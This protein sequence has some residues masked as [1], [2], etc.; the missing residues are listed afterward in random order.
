[1]VVVEVVLQGRL[2]GLTRL[3]ILE[4]HLL[5]PDLLQDG[6][7]LIVVEEVDHRV[8][9]NHKNQK[10]TALVV[11]RARLFIAHRINEVKV[12]CQNPTAGLTHTVVQ[13]FLVKTSSW[14]LCL[15]DVRF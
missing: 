3:L 6:R 10:S 11:D 14:F 13:Q 4:E 5:D 7:Q 12:V 8:L 15:C 9:Q 2:V 1:M